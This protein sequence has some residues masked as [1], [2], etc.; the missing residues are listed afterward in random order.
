MEKKTLIAGAVATAITVGTFGVATA[1]TSSH[2][3]KAVSTKTTRP[4]ISGVAANAAP[5]ANGVNPMKTILDGLV[6]KGTITAAQESA[7][8]AA[9]DAARPVGGHEGGP[10]GDMDRGGYG[11][12]GGANFAAEQST[13]LTTLGIDAATLNAGL[14]A[15][16]SLATIAGSKTQALIDALV[17]L[18]NKEIDAAVTAGQLTAAQATTEK[19]NTVA[20]VTARVNATPGQPGMGMGRGRHGHGPGWAPGSTGTTGT[21]APQANG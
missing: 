19:A 10:D 5:M 15:G 9:F 12:D 17:A 7:I 14:T 6:T 20:R 8:I 18:E 3:T 21:N 13:I 11:P 16:K 1:A 2:S 4:S